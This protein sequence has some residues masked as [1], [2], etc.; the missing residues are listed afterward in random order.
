[1]K[2]RVLF[3]TFFI[4]TIYLL[5]A[6]TNAQKRQRFIEA[7]KT[8]L[9]VPYVW[10]GMSRAGIDCS[11]FIAAAY[12]D[13]GLGTL[14]HSAKMIYSQSTK[15]SDSQREPGDL[16][17][18]TDAGVISHVSLYI[19]NNQVI[20]AISD[21][22]RTGVTISKLSENYWKTHYFAMGRI[23]GPGSSSG[24]IASSGKKGSSKKKKKNKNPVFVFDTTFY[25]D[26]D[27]LT[28]DI[29]KYNFHMNGGTIQADLLLTYFPIKPGIMAK[30]TYLY[31]AD[32]EKFNV[33]NLFKDFRLP[34]CFELFVNDYVGLYSGVVFSSQ[35]KANEPTLYC[36]DGTTKKLATPLYPG[37]F[38]ITFK[39]PDLTLGRVQFSL[40][41]D[42]SY[43][44]Y[45]AA[46]GED[47]LTIA[48]MLSAGVSF[49]TGLRVRL[50]F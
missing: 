17:F 50:P 30:Y 26:Y 27:F 29:N 48:E 9:G 10:G 23:I 40:A 22:P 24:L 5:G 21:G 14:P 4:F 13:A 1:M 45:T 37:I 11:G 38:G 41:Q 31:Q 35:V 32:G 18:F 39:T 44:H 25:A 43:T 33:D 3:T 36:N 12:R 49:S 7:G 15:I 2:K 34:V 20:H 19:G 6:Q 46:E 8:Y 28:T 47:A 16:V 42:I